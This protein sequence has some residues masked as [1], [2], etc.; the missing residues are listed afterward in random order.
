MQLK[1]QLLVHTG[2]REWLW[3]KVFDASQCT[4][5][6]MVIDGGRRG[7][8][9]GIQGKVDVAAQD[10]KGLRVGPFVCVVH[11]GKQVCTD[12]KS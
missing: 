7:V 4:G 12:F 10:S 9:I 1:S 11:E 3:F 2:V 6:G 8:R 5:D